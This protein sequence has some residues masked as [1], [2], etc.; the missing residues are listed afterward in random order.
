[1]HNFVPQF[2]PNIRLYTD[3]FF[4]YLISFENSF[5]VLYGTI[6]ILYRHLYRQTGFLT[7]CQK[8]TN[9]ANVVFTGFLLVAEAGFEPTT[10][11]L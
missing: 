4:G 5:D 6:Q 1:M 2:V 9:P 3:F 11:G 8:I 10:F 7:D